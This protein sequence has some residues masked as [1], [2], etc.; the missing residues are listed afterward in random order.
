LQTIGDLFLLI[1][2]RGDV[3][4]PF[5]NTYRTMCLAPQP[6]FRQFTRAS[7]RF[8]DRGIDYR[9]VGITAPDPPINPIIGFAAGAQGMRHPSGRRPLADEPE[10]VGSEAR[11]L[12]WRNRSQRNA[13]KMVDHD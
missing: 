10:A 13:P 7:P 11:S 1:P 3:P 4:L 8:A 6:E 12:R 9:F 5:L 2:T